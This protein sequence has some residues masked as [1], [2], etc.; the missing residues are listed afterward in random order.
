M[1]ALVVL[2]QPPTLEGNA[3]G[4]C[5]VA[6]LRG[7]AA[8]GVEVEA[9]AAR[10]SFSADDAVPDDLRVEVVDIRNLPDQP[11]LGRLRRPRGTLLGPL[12]DRLHER[13]SE[14]DVIHLE[15][16]ETAW[17]DLGIEQPSSLHMHFRVLRDRRIPPPWRHEFRFLGEYA[18]AELVAARRHKFLVAN[19]QRIADSLHRLNRKAEVV[20]VPLTLDPEHYHRAPLDGPPV[21]GI[22]GS[23]DWPPTAN[24]VARLA[25]RVWPLV[26]RE[27]RDARL[28][29]A[30]RGT[31]RLA[32][33]DAEERGLDFVGEV[34]SAA[35]FME[36]LS[37]LLYPVERGSGMKVKVL[38]A[39]ACGV[40][41]V[42]TKDGAEGV[43]ENAGVQVDATDAEIAASAV[44]ILRDEGER[45]ERG[46]AGYS[47]FVELY[48]PRP[49]ARPLAELFARMAER[50]AR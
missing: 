49:A 44:G 39:L 36:Q 21:A 25:H 16:T 28:V 13:A 48:S 5:A 9:L 50:R 33:P 30:G 29:I 27:V 23:G 19:S 2:A 47:A 38:E 4:R 41:V 42:T 22:I 11:F 8:H 37:M 18:T 32:V 43:A 20:V 17:C 14:F 3:P 46:A 6:L 26:R 15:E 40:P 24:A 31:E 7:L 45:R 35:S 34:P 1:K 12:S 10:Q